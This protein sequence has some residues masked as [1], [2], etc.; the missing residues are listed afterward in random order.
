MKK[1]AKILLKKGKKFESKGNYSDAIAAYERALSESPGDPDILFALGIVARKMGI[2]PVAEEMFRS[3]YGLLPDSVEAATNLA[4]TIN[5]QDRPEEAIEIYKS[6]LMTN[7]EHVATWINLGNAVIRTGD[8]GKAEI[9]IQEALRLKPASIEALTN[10]SELMMVK[11][12]YEAAL[13]LIDKAHRRDRRNANIRF[14]RGQ[15]LLALG[16]LKDGW[17][18]LNNGERNRKDRQIIYHHKLRDWAGEDLVGKKILLSCEQGI[19]D[20]VRFLNCLQAVIERA[21]EVHVETE[22][23]LVGL[24]SRTYPKAIVRAYDSE[25]IADI[26]HVNYDWAVNEL[27]YASSMFGAYQFT[28][29]DVS[30]FDN[31]RPQFIT[32]A[33][34]DDKWQ[35]KV[36]ANASGLKVGICWH[37][38]KHSLIRDMEY[39]DIDHWQPILTQ[40]N[41]SFFNLMYEECADEVSEIKEKFDA[42]IITFEGLDYK[43]DLED[44][45]SLT[46][47]MDVVISVNSAPA[48]FSGVLGIPTYMPARGRGW[49]ML[50]TNALATVPN[51]KPIMQSE[52][53][54]WSPVFDQLATI[55]KSYIS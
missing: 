53:G 25:R 32:E 37:G 19:G 2:L 23:R 34:L 36:C 10:M 5:N 39:P 18:Q 15:I 44:V 46:K 43:N 55:L 40:K 1:S 24:L 21:E 33:E 22:P 9:F 13:T 11:G 16:R 42:D 48:A 28:H 45:F 12:D 52:A 41:V 8:F 27:D 50:G 49:E 38:G 26:V 20:Q 4:I 35:K 51:M 54:D 17:R 30:A 47:Q 3:V 29:S 7:P 6:L 14:N 31:K